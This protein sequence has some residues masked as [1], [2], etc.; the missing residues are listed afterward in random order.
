ME[1]SLEKIPIAAAS[2]ELKALKEVK[3][4]VPGEEG[5]LIE[6]YETSDLRG[7][8]LPREDPRRERPVRFLDLTNASRGLGLFLLLQGGNIALQRMTLRKSVQ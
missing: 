8:Q 3:N 2:P 6:V 7:A 5:P 4:W 1:L